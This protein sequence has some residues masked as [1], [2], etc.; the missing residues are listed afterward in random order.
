MTDVSALAPAGLMSDAP[1]AVS[2]V[3]TGLSHVADITARA[4]AGLML[5]PPTVASSV[6]SDLSHWA[7]GGAPAAIGLLHNLAGQNSANGSEGLQLA[8]GTAPSSVPISDFSQLDNTDVLAPTSS[9]VAL[10]EQTG[11]L[12]PGMPLA[13]TPELSSTALDCRAASAA[14]HQAVDLVASRVAAAPDVSHLAAPTVSSS[15]MP[16]VI[17]SAAAAQLAENAPANSIFRQSGAVL[18]FVPVALS[19]APV[20]SSSDLPH[21]AGDEDMQGSAD[22]S[23]ALLTAPSSILSVAAVRVDPG[24]AAQIKAA[25]T[26]PSSIVSDITDLALVGGLAQQPDSAVDT[27]PGAVVWTRAATTA[28]SSI[29]SGLTDLVTAGRVAQHA[30]IAPDGADVAAMCHQA[31]YVHT[32]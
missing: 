10:A 4:A 19:T 20:S 17:H 14:A 18:Y 25:T 11:A 12:H 5:E 27:D 29:V 7:Q 15:M 24:A 21:I 16:D 9:T 13:A 26:A 3:V 30:N 28:P 31:R 22:G 8:A 2:S 1:T 6:I 23:P 32:V